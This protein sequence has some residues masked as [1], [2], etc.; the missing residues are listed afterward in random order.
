MATR[1]REAERLFAEL[2]RFVHGVSQAATRELAGH[3][4]TPAQYQVLVRVGARPEST[5]QHLSEQLGVTKSNVSMLVDRLEQAGLLRRRPAGAAYDLM[6]TDAGRAR[7]A[8]LRPR[9]AAFMAERFAVLD[10]DRFEQL[11]ALVAAL[12]P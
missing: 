2:V 3:G 5:Q 1:E 10:D 12:R 7:V 8:E 9:Q 11:A 4:L 6:L